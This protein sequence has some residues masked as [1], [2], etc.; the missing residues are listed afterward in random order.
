MGNPSRHNLQKRMSVRV[1]K[2]GDVISFK[3]N[4]SGT[5]DIPAFLCKRYDI[6]IDN[7][8]LTKDFPLEELSN[9]P[10]IVLKRI[11]WYEL[12]IEV[13]GYLVLVGDKKTIISSKI[14]LKNSL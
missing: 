1:Y 5:Y 8:Y 13:S 9:Y 14:L 6:K 10:V 4:L 2:P 11:Y 7:F 3:E 12:L